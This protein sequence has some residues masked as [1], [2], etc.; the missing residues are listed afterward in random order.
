[1]FCG[2]KC[3]DTAKVFASRLQQIEQQKAARKK[4]VS[5][6]VTG[7]VKIIILIAV[8]FALY[9]FVVVKFLR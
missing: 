9:K 4:S 7:I 8:L 2:E 6:A 1:V 3:A 5:A